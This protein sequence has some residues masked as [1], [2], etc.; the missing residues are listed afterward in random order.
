MSNSQYTLPEAAS[1][2]MES[3]FGV[4]PNDAHTAIEVGLNRKVTTGEVKAVIGW[5]TSLTVRQNGNK[6]IVS[7]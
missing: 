3:G 1:E 7:E 4:L 2:L 6:V 5:D